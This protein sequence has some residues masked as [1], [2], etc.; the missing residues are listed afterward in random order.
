MKGRNEKSFVLVV[1]VESRVG[2]INFS[3][4]SSIVWLV[5]T[6]SMIRRG[7]FS[8]E[9]IFFKEWVLIILVFFVLLVKKLLILE[10]VLLKV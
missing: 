8:L 4:K 6:S 3:M 2:F 1:V 5:F 10:I 9:I 7:F